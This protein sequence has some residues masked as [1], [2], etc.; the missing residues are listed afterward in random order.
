MNDKFINEIESELNQAIYRQ[1]Q[2][3]RRIEILQAESIVVGE[4]ASKLIK[5]SLSKLSSLKETI[6]PIQIEG[7]T[8]SGM[9]FQKIEKQEVKW[10][11]ADSNPVDIKDNDFLKVIDCGFAHYKL[12]Q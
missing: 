12:K 3:N 2:M 4:Y 7:L 5:N 6:I 1:S 9:V 10:V 11:D 8:F